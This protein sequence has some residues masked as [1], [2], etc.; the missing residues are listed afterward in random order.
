MTV[1]V[2]TD[3]LLALTKDSDW[4]QNS[5]EDALVENDVETSAFSYLELLLARE[6][7]EFDYVPLVANLL[8]LVPV[9]NEEEKQVVLKAVNY[10]DEGMTPFDAFHAATAETR[11]M[12]VLSSEK[13]YEEIEVERVPLEPTDEG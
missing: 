9:R 2:E 3:F 1:Y 5:A 10:Y 6:R 12:D 13:D 8:E 7:Y 4:L 11:G